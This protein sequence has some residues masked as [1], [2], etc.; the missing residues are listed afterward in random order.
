MRRVSGDCLAYVTAT[1]DF[2]QDCV[3]AGAR[4]ITPR[5]STARWWIDCIYCFPMASESAWRIQATGVSWC[6]SSAHTAAQPQCSTL[7]SFEKFAAIV[8]PKKKIDNSDAGRIHSHTK[9][10][11]M[12]EALTLV[13]ACGTAALKLVALHLHR[14]LLPVLG[15]HGWLSARTHWPKPLRLGLRVV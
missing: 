14:K 5:G 4:A 1:H 12:V 7:L 9:S 13:E 3:A 2:G 10:S 15:P 11:R 8:I 6:L